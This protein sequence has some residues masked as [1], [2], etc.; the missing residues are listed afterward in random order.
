M[1]SPLTILGSGHSD[2]NLVLFDGSDSAESSRFLKGLLHDAAQ[3]PS[4][5]MLLLDGGSTLSPSFATLPGFTLLDPRSGPSVGLFDGLC[6]SAVAETVA[7]IDHP[8][9]PVTHSSRIHSAARRHTF[10]CATLLHALVQADKNAVAG[11]GQCRTWKWTPVDLLR[12]HEEVGAAQAQYAG[13]RLEALVQS[14]GSAASHPVPRFGEAV[15]YVSREV[16]LVPTSTY[17]PIADTVSSWVRPLTALAWA[18]VEEGFDISAVLEGGRVV[19]SLP[20]D[21]HGAIVSKFIRHRIFNAL[22][23]REH[24]L[25]SSSSRLLLFVDDAHLSLCEF[26][27]RFA[28]VARSLGCRLIYR[29]ES[30]QSLRA[31]L[32]GHVEV[33]RLL[34]EFPTK[35]AHLP[36]KRTLRYLREQHVAAWGY[37]QS[38][39]RSPSRWRAILSRLIHPATA[40]TESSL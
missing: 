21:D 24:E 29:T 5:G 23:V 10:F 20:E 32:G 25:K 36:N 37:S 27:R 7:S 40:T 6:P 26:D 15:D 8:I 13:S 39:R 38:T 18:S 34:V 2:R 35:V 17:L 31:S 11:T 14:L 33:A 28:P 19:V 4:R 1:K 30:Y 12:L 16:G 9:D 22:R 3:D